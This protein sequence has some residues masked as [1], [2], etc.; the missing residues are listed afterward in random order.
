MHPLDTVT[1][2]WPPI[3]TKF[4]VF[5]D[6]L[7]FVS[8]TAFNGYG[9]ETLFSGRVINRFGCKWAS[10]S[11]FRMD[12]CLDNNQV[13]MRK[14][15]ARSRISWERT[16]VNSISCRGINI[17]RLWTAGLILFSSYCDFD[18]FAGQLYPPHHL[19]SRKNEEI[20]LNV[21]II[22]IFSCIVVIPV[23]CR[24]SFNRNKTSE[25]TKSS[26]KYCR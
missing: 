6:F 3:L 14:T 7:V 8:L 2:K 20:I 26:P 9:I 10:I 13:P 16:S 24:L 21:Y 25:I 4:T 17:T 15:E 23:Q 19:L 1:Q 5:T 12:S 18:G 11:C 22:N